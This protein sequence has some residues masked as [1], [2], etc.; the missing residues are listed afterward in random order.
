MVEAGW[1]QL[2]TC[3][4]PQGL[5]SFPLTNDCP[6]TLYTDA[7][8]SGLKMS[9]MRIALILSNSGSEVDASA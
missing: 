8:P 1:H 6:D 7:S 2:W 4:F 9:Q 5:L 3:I